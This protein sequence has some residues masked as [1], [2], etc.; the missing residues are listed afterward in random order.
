MQLLDYE[1]EALVATRMGSFQS[2]MTVVTAGLRLT[3]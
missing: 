3:L 2:C 1:R